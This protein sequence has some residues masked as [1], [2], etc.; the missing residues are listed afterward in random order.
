MTACGLRVV[1]YI[2]RNAYLVYAEP[3]DLAKISSLPM[4]HWQGEYLYEYK[5]QPSIATVPTE[6]YVVQLFLDPPANESTIDLIRSLA[7][8]EPD[9]WQVLHYVN[10]SAPLPLETLETVA[11]RPDVIS[12]APRGFYEWWDE[13][14]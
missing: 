8:A 9:V 5:L 7:G 2:Q 4:L 11:K 12:V 6:K 1:D 14:R 10:V 3:V 13:R